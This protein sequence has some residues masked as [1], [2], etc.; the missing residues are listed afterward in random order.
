MR[1]RVGFRFERFFHPFACD[2]AKALSKGG[3]DDLLTL[4]NQTLGNPYLQAPWRLGYQIIRHEDRRHGLDRKRVARGEHR[5][6]ANL[7][8]ETHEGIPRREVL[9]EAQLPGPS[10]SR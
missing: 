2:Y 4:G 6:P 7:R 3:L 5:R 8:A 10:R 1:W 9:L